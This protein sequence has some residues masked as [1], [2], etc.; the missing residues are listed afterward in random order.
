MQVTFRPYRRRDGSVMIY[1]NGSNGASVGL[2]DQPLATSK[3]TKG[4]QNTLNA[5]LA[6]FNLHAEPFLGSLGAHTEGQYLCGNYTLCITDV[7][8]VGG[9]STG[10]DGA[11]LVRDGK[12]LACDYEYDSEP[13]EQGDGE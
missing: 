8:T 1:I 10:A 11:F 2:S 4:Q 9:H 5:G 7:A 12:I 3:L 6:A 13:T